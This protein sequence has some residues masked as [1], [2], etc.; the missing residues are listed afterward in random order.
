MV[1]RSK[2]TH[3]NGTSASRSQNVGRVNM[4]NAE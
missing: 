4:T 1:V 2:M 3:A